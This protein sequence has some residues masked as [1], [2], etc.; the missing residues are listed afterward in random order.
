MGNN[1]YKQILTR[2]TILGIVLGLI[3]AFILL[4]IERTLWLPLELESINARNKASVK[5]DKDVTTQDI[6]L[7]LFDD[8]T[9]FLLRE[10]GLPIRDFEV[11]GRKL[12]NSILKKLQSYD[13]KSIGINLDLRANSDPEVD[14]EL[15]EII[16][17]SKNLVVADS[18]YL[19]TQTKN[20]ILKS[21]AHIGYGELYAD[22][23]DVVHEIKLQD[24]KLGLVPSFSYE[25]FKVSSGKDISKKHKD[26]KSFYLRY[27]KNGF[28]QISII[29]IVN[30]SVDKLELKDK[31]VIIGVALKS[32]LMG[33]K[34][35]NPFGTHISDSGVQAVAVHN[36]LHESYLFKK[37]LLSCPILFIF[38]SI[39]F[40]LIFSNT[41]P[42]KGL[43]LA[44]LLFSL[45]VFLSQIAYNSLNLLIEIVP[46]LFLLIVNFV[47]GSLIFLQL[48]LKERNIELEDAL[49]MLSKKTK[50][51]EGSKKEIEEKNFELFTTLN[52]LNKKV[53]ELHETR[54]QISHKRE[55]ERKRIAR[56]LHDDTLARITDLKRHIELALSSTDLSS[57]IKK[58]LTEYVDILDGVTKEIRRII[59]ALRPS[60]LDNTLGLLPAIENLL[61]EL[62]K[63]SQN[64][65]QTK[66]TTS[67]KKL[68]LDEVIE[69]HLY[70]IV[71]EALNN[72]FKHSGAT[73]AE[74]K[75][76]EQQ[77][78]LLILVSDNGKGIKDLDLKKGFGV[79]DMKERSDLIGASIQYINKPENTGATL[80]I[81]FDTSNG[82]MDIERK[83]IARAL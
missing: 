15:A 62:S 33:D 79:I 45:I 35:V 76:E 71:Q 26:K 58:E 30:G 46:V 68:K 7:V 44:T 60:M 24:K 69:I 16:S 66:L 31:I 2:K 37:T 77:G 67:L 74:I 55:E 19:T 34:L 21:A 63:R 43:I 49:R 73:S 3:V 8:K 51:L 9:K 50:E 39:I 54:K 41:R 59:N 82:K 1:Q 42:V 13:V 70:R 18:I 75:I 65:I 23:D 52:E 80:E 12:L 11:S 28:K 47:V 5:Q 20:N 6:V 40:G 61:D 4:K 14:K 27:P 78:Q 25:L 64:K 38:L 10:N 57:G 48:D 22:Y 17:K 83:E 29:D 72:V 56:E 36:L 32:K 81:T 53:S